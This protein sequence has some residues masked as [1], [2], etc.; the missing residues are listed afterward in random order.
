ME[1]GPREVVALPLEEDTG[2]C[3]VWSRTVSPY[4]DGRQQEA[5][6]HLPGLAG[7][8]G[9]AAAAPP[10]QAAA[11]LSGH[12]KFFCEGRRRLS[13]MAFRFLFLLR[14]LSSFPLLFSSAYFSASSNFLFSAAKE[15]GAGL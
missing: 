13:L 9:M 4:G 5:G 3:K 12:H 14:K 10:L 15:R 6:G 11:R 7:A 2:R 8:E 1:Q